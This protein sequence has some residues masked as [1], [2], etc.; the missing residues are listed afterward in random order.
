M[1]I[2]ILLQSPTENHLHGITEMIIFVNTIVW[3]MNQRLQQFI[4]AEN[5][6]Q[7]QFADLLKVARAS[8]SNILSGRNKPGFDF[9]ESLS[10]HFPDLNLEWLVTGRGRMY[11][12]RTESLP[13][14]TSESPVPTDG[15][16][17]P[18]SQP[19]ENPVFAADPVPPG[20]IPASQTVVQ[21]E[22]K[23]DRILVFFSD[24][25]YQEIIS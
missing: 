10:L 23:V 4:Q 20:R 16:L 7:A 22:K 13:S 8:V 2:H 6:S 5:L 14:I 11:K 25:T 24:G 3:D 15:L 19:A 9:L 12:S 1:G 17:F 18:D 21:S